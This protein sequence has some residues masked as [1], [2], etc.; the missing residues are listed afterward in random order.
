MQIYRI[1]HTVSIGGIICSGGMN[2]LK[3]RVR[4]GVNVDKELAEK[5][6]KL[7]ELTRIPTSRL[8]DEAIS[9]LLTKHEVDSR[10]N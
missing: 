8:F 5:I 3:T 1:L 4:L 6:K 2:M 7:S 9:D 10:G